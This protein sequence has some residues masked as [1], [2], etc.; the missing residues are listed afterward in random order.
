MMVTVWTTIFGGVV[1]FAIVAYIWIAGGK[2]EKELE[3]REREA[4][5]ALPN[6]AE[7]THP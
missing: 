4:S 2:A 6:K 5:D 1:T 7:H 3:R